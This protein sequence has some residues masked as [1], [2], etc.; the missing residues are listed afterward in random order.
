MVNDCSVLEL[1][2]KHVVVCVV[3]ETVPSIKYLMD[4]GTVSL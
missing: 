4:F 1:H 3:K 2:L